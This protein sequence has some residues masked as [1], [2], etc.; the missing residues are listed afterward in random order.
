MPSRKE[1][2]DE[3]LDIIEEH[4]DCDGGPE[5]AHIIADKVEE[6]IKNSKNEENKNNYNTGKESVS[7]P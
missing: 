5:A 1:I 6:W 4:Y 3:V 7:R 2:E